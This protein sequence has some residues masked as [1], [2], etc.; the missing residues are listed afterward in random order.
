MERLISLCVF[1]CL[2][3]S[4]WAADIPSPSGELV[5]KYQDEVE[6]SV[7]AD[8]LAKRV[9]YFSNW[10]VYR[11]GIGSYDIDDIPGEMCTHIIYSF[12]GVSN[13]TWGVLV[14]DPERDIDNGGY[15]KF[16][17]LK[18][19]YPHLKPMLAVGGWGEGGK[20]YSQMA[21]VPSRRESFVRSVVEYMNEWIRWIRSRLGISWCY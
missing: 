6:T 7:D 9:C 19:K 4:I 17:G 18:Q 16:V 20:K 5:K 8:R 3:S 15:A 21:S 13:V 11:P 2:T 14:L 12:C 1:L 10:A